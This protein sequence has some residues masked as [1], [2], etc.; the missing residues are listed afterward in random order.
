MRSKTY[1]SELTKGKAG[2]NEI[3]FIDTMDKELI[4]LR[5]QLDYHNE[6]ERDWQSHIKRDRLEKI[7]RNQK[8][9][10]KNY[11]EQTADT[12][13]IEA[14]TKITLKVGGSTIEMTPMAINIKSTMITSEAG[15]INTIKGA[16]VKIN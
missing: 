5:A 13:L 2:F 6:V 1:P 12:I 16:L 4:R 10:I 14:K 15:A 3:R 9:N 8:I 7:D 11:S